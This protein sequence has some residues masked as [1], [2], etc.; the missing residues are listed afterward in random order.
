[1]TGLA[2]QISIY[3]LRQ[4]H[5]S[6]TIDDVVQVFRNHEGLEVRPGS[7]STLVIGNDDEIFAALKDALRNAAAKGEVVMVATLSNA[8]PI[9][10]PAPSSREE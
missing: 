3:P 2:A 5:L 9:P 4:P 6:P 1:M 7:M 8:C 10:G